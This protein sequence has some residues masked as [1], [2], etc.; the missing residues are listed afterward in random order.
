MAS[1][2]SPIVEFD[3]ALLDQLSCEGD[4]EA[5]AVIAAHM[6][7]TGHADVK[8]LMRDIG[9]AL[10]FPPTTGSRPSDGPLLH[11]LS[12][13]PPLPEWVDDGRMNRAA[14]VFLD[15]ALG[16]GQALFC[17]SLPEAYASP[18]GARVLT[19][20]AR[21]TRDPVRRISETAQMVYDVVTSQGLV[22]VVL[23]E[24]RGPSGVG[25]ADARRV[26]LM[27]AAVRW[28]I[29]HDASVEHRQGPP[30]ATTVEP[31]WFDE[32]GIPLNQEDLLGT[33]MTFTVAVFEALE[34]SGEALDDADA[35]AYLHRWCVV[36]HL[37][38]IR[39]DLL[40]FDLAT[41]RSLTASIR[42]RQQR[43]SA[44]GK[45]LTA[46]LITPLRA[47]LPLRPLRGIVPALIRHLIT[48][49][50]AAMIGVRVNLW[51]LVVDG[52]LRLLNAVGTRWLRREIHHSPI[53][54]WLSRYA[55]R[56]L[57]GVFLG[58]NRS[59]GRPAFAIPDEMRPAIEGRIPKRWR[60][61]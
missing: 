8:V 10:A 56:R 46:A 25:Y 47:S 23:T 3:D 9:E 19:L 17:A 52:P 24:Q 22:P 61:P 20:T 15:N 41:A 31:V 58:A 32:W 4:P 37:M 39:A 48:P 36:G 54:R 43:T 53:I 59:S 21:L 5:D 35:E 6:A 33:L 29:L 11:Y 34:R 30:A 26:R 55:A 14:Q 27:H 50:I 49:R 57:V 2:D 28:F 45:A 16:I 13:A 38:G 7:A 12:A 51:E 40:P 1:P 42:R 18:R 44:D 60:L